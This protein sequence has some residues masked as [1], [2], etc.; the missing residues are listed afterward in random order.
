MEY[1]SEVHHR[2]S[3][4]LKDYD[5]SQ[6]G[7][8]F[9]TICTQHKACL[10]GEIK[11]AKM[12][13]NIA[14]QIIKKW[15]LKIP[16]KFPA[17]TIDEYIIMPN[18]IHGICMIFESNVGADPCVC[19][20]KND[21]SICLEDE[22][23]GSPLHKIIQWF[24]TMTTNECIRSVKQNILPQFHGRLWQRNYYEHIIRNEDDLNQIRE[25]IS[26]NP[27][28][29][30]TDKENPNKINVHIKQNERL[31]GTGTEE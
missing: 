31:N 28:K 29:W 6:P 2:R 16:N 18:H 20:N 12:E 21:Q 4:R 7:G 15:W 1:S 3:I 30:E 14:G 19:P 25:Y 22:H 23:S 13:L 26:G 5:Y 27:V 11:D 10:F 8:Y 24:K 9:I 17:I